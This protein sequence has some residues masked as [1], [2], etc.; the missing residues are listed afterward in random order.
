MPETGPARKSVALAK[1]EATPEPPRKKK[2]RPRGVAS[3]EALPVAMVNSSTTPWMSC[4]RVQ[5]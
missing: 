1:S 3:E 5:S 4:M 2:P